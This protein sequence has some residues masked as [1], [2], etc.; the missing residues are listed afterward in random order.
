M[1]A[2][3]PELHA[4][5]SQ[6]EDLL[7]A[8]RALCRMAMQ[9]LAA[10][11]DRTS[12]NECVRSP[13]L[14]DSPLLRHAVH[15]ALAA[16][17]PSRC[18]WVGVRTLA[19]GPRRLTVAELSVAVVSHPD[20]RHMLADVLSRFGG[21]P[22]A[23][24]LLTASSEPRFSRDLTS[25]TA[26]LELALTASSA[27]IHDLLPHVSLVA[28]LNDAAGVRSA[29]LRE[30]PGLVLVASPQSALAAAE[31]LV[32]EAAHQKFF[33]LALVHDLLNTVS[34][35]C[36]PFAPPW[37]HAGTLWPIEQTLAALHTYACLAQL[38][39]DVDGT[40][41]QQPVDARSLLPA[42]P[43]RVDVI[44]Q[45]LIAHS[46]YLGPDARFLVNALLNLEPTYAQQESDSR[47]EPN[48]AVVR[49]HPCL[50]I[51]LDAA[52]GRVLVGRSEQPY[53]FYFLDPDSGLL[54]EL[55][56]ERQLEQAIRDFARRRHLDRRQAERLTASILP[57]LATAGLISVDTEE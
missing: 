9:L 34:D 36:P 41:G 45:W 10:D 15:E 3:I 4:R 46:A 22:T 12:L 27:M 8:R 28:I 20:A 40:P 48:N 52:S 23:M 14:L 43:E 50:H 26:G 37:H 6:P 51:D 21:G 32:H 54:L 42:A 49:A 16:G 18:D 39:R 33:D 30:Y 25:L 55:L 19:N 53:D 44:G 1:T 24:S 17:A 2:A 38:A 35:T 29:S 57:R 5:L 11:E 13:A 31:M 47:S 56:R 7:R